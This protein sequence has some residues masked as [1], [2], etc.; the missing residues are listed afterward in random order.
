MDDK[1]Q[2]RQRRRAR[3]N[4]AWGA[5]VCGLLFVVAMVLAE[6][7]QQPV[8][9]Q[10]SP[11]PHSPFAG[12]LDGDP[13][14]IAR[15]ERAL[16]AER[17][18]SMVADTDKLLKLARELNDEIGHSN[19]SVLTPEE[20]RKVADIEKLARNVKQKMSISYTVALPID[21]LGPR[22]MP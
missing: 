20:L 1:L 5:A 19:P 11:L 17:Q 2:I 15:H 16:N 6:P 7:G 22:E 8:P 3:G 18:K 12:S 14:L 9:N 10:V 21:G 13:A 4:V